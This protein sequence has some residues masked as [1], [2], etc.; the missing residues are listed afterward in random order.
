MLDGR[1]V[2]DDKLERILNKWSMIY[3][4]LLTVPGLSWRE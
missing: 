2:V 4:K 1:R 3:F